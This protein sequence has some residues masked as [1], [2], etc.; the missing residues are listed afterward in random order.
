MTSINNDNEVE[1][2]RLRVAELEKSETRYRGIF[3]NS[4]ISLWE[5]DW[6]AVNTRL[7]QLVASG[8]ADL[9]AYFG[10]HF[11]EVI[12]CVKLVKIIDINRATLNLCRAETKEQIFSGLHVIFNEATLGTFRRELVAIG[13][14]ATSYEEECVICTV[15]GEQRNVM[16]R[17]A[18]SENYEK[19]WERAF[20]SLVD[21]TDRKEAE[22]ELRRS[23]EETIRAQSRTLAKLSTPVI[24]ISDQVIVMPLIGD[25]DTSR[26]QLAMSTLLDEVQRWQTR[27]AILDITGVPDIDEEA[28]EGIIRAAQAVRLLGA[29]VV[30]TGIRADVARRVIDLGSSLQGIVTRSTLRSGIAYAIGEGA[31]TGGLGRLGRR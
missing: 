24:P 2:L 4:P 26:M 17:L 6:S 7:N 28:A 16:F 13:K 8:V 21:I 1:S 20:V 12:E 3:E 22:E 10:S 19:T 27:F 25:L 11:D 14:G 18:V 30:L 15:D 9:D 5:E 23:K 31:S 29:Q